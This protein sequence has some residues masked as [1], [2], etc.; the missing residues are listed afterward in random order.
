MRRVV[1][2][3]Y[4]I[5]NLIF[6]VDRCQKNGI[7]SR[8]EFYFLMKMRISN[9]KGLEHG[10]SSNA[11][12]AIPVPKS[13]RRLKGDIYPTGPFDCELR[14]VEVVSTF[15]SLAVLHERHLGF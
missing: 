15:I 2:S 4:C 10:S 5:A 12:V 9:K 7:H 8:S 1:A 14:V 11:D 3:S 6:L 13:D